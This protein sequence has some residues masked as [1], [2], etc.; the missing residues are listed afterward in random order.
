MDDLGL[1]HEEIRNVSRM[2]ESGEIRTAPRAFCEAYGKLLQFM[3]VG[4]PANAAKVRLACHLENEWPVHVEPHITALLES[5]GKLEM[6]RD[7]LRRITVPVLTIHGTKDRNAPYG[8]GR[9]WAAA[10]PNARLVTVEGAAHKSW[11]DDPV[12][13]FAAIR[14]FLRG[15]WPYD[16]ERVT[17]VDPRAGSH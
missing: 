3:L 13:V 10:L 7:D 17:A 16:A 8:G 11:A 2:R 9:E 14:R 1:P 5:I 15:D 4:N 6:S 12:T